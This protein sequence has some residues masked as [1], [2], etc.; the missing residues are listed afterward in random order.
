[1]YKWLSAQNEIR[2]KSWLKILDFLLRQKKI[3]QKEEDTI[4]SNLKDA[5]YLGMR[6][7]ESVKNANTIGSLMTIKN[8]TLLEQSNFIPLLSLRNHL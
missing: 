6:M 7:I 4:K 2:Q 5:L 1:M 3:P 8:Y